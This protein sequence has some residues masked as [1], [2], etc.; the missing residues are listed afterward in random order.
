M[1]GVWV[2]NAD[3]EGRAGLTGVGYAA[4]VM[5]SIF[6]GLPDGPWFS[7]P[8]D[9]MTEIEVC[10]ESG[11]PAGEYCVSRD[12]LWVHQAGIEVRPCPYHRLV[13][14]SPD[15]RWQVNT[16]C[17]DLDSIVTQSWFVLPPA[18][19]WYYRRSHL[20]YMSL[21]PFR[22]DCD[23]DEV[24]TLQ[25]LYPEPNSVLVRTVNMQGE[26]GAIVFRAA[27]ANEHTTLYWHL[28][29]TFVGETVGDHR[30]AL[31]P[32]IG[33]HVLVLTDSDGHSASVRFEVR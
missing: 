20:D 30:L 28:D 21:P 4:P 9:E 17:V 25:V 26:L 11:H 7:Q 10:R 1:V 27:H 18:M 5:F 2:G 19:A 22:G 14:L 6:A 29:Q 33:S 23:T 3:G 16:S 15:K 13:H 32:E 12:S 31:E 24:P 8:Y